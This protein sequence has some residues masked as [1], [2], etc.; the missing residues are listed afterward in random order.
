MTTTGARPV[1]SV[2]EEF[3]IVDGTRFSIARSAGL[4]PE[5][6]AKPRTTPTV[7]LYRGGNDIILID[8][9]ASLSEISQRPK[10]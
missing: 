3:E 7:V 8:S 2:D 1:L 5:T 4:L 6:T 10:L 9:L